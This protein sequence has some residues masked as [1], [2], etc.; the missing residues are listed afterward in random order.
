MV[1]LICIYIYLSY[2]NNIPF[3]FPVD[4]L[5]IYSEVASG[6]KSDYPT[7]ATCSSSRRCYCVN[8]VKSFI[9]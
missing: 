9:I 7:R 4:K 3:Q 8:F 5:S 6:P 1:A 2:D